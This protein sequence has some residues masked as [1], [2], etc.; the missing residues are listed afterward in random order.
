MAMRYIYLSDLK[1]AMKFVK[2]LQGATLDDPSMGM[3]KKALHHLW[4]PPCDQSSIAINEVTHL[5]IDLYMGTTSED[6][7]DVMIDLKISFS[8]AP[9]EVPP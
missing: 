5:A 1:T 8:L 9:Q 6:T 3:S 2:G 7:Y 4:N